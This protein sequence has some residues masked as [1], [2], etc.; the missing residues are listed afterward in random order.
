MSR[1]LR[2]LAG[3]RR[4]NQLIAEHQPLAGLDLLMRQRPKSGEVDLRDF[5]W[6]YLLKRCHTEQ[7]TLWGH[8]GD[9]RHVEFSPDG[10]LLAT[11]GKDGTIRL[12]DASTCKF[13][14]SIQAHKD[15]AN[16]VTFSPDGR[17]LA[18]CGDDGT[19]R[20][21]DVA[22][23]REPVVI[24]A[25]IGAVATA[26]FTPDGQKLIS[27]GRTDEKVKIAN[28]ETGLASELLQ[29]KVGD[30]EGMAVLST[31]GATLARA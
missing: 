5:A 30:F 15:G 1:R 26:Q 12:W 27:V 25:H 19:I 29:L 28:A 14:R 2:Y 13:L 23:D 10:K 8:Q 16:W 20:I 31:D 18:S 24:A 21:C 7:N 11:T 4:A 22:G 9:V 17:V 3:I 6:H